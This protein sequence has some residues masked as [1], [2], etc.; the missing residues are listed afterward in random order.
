MREGANEVE[1]AD[2][3]PGFRARWE[4][5]TTTASEF[6]EEEEEEEAGG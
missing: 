6:E 2:N 4:V 3:W 1:I 5:E